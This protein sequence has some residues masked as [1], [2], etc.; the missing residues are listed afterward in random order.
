M[1]SGLVLLVGAVVLWACATVPGTG[2]LQLL[3]T[4]AA[5]ENRLGLEASQQ[6]LAKERRSSD[7]EINALV[8]RVGQRIAA[9]TPAASS[10][11]WEYTVLDSKE[12]NAFCLPGGKVFVYTGILPYCGSEAGLATVVGH[13]VAH[14]VAR[15]GG[16]RMSQ[17]L[18]AQLGGS[19]VAAA[20]A[21][22][23]VP[24]TTTNVMLAAYGAGAQLGV[25]LP[26]SRTH[27]LEADRLGIEY[28]ARAGYDPNEAVAF[29]RTFGQ[30][31]KADRATFFSTHPS[32]AERESQLA[33]LLPG[34]LELYAQ[35]PRHGRGATLVTEAR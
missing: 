16:E 22:A 21:T 30:R 2:R 29:W 24:P 8:E 31:K 23:G 10:F 32:S 20:L 7:P 1:R 19:V 15:H 28:M 33:R 25:L 18:L 4:S 13:E 6:I 27:E 17:G 34:A 5:E 11:R 26:Y 12:P 3:L 35:S 14:A 9:V